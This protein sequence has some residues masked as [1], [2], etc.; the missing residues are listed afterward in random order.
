[1]PAL[2][3]LSLPLTPPTT[4][5][6]SMYFFYLFIALS[7]IKAD[8]RNILDVYSICKYTFFMSHEVLYSWGG[9]KNALGNKLLLL[10]VY[11]KMVSAMLAT[12][13]T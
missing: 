11:I 10:L 7:T 5:R 13:T 2:L 3:L 4:Q 9:K 12:P 1:M 6:L 8:V